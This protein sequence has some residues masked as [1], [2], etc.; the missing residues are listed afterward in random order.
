MNVRGGFWYCTYEEGLNAEFFVILLR[1]IMQH[2]TEPVHL[3]LDSLP[4]HKTALVKAYVASTNGL[5]TPHFL[6]EYAP[7][8][9]DN[10]L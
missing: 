7:E 5:L 1:R 3:V 10:C 4:I 6:P 9:G 2:R 8:R